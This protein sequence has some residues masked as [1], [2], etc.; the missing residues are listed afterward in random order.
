MKPVTE[1]RI[2]WGWPPAILNPNRKAHWGRRGHARA[3]YRQDCRLSALCAMKRWRPAPPWNRARID[4]V[5]YAPDARRRDEDNMV[6]SL[7]AAFDSLQDAG[8]IGDDYYLTR[9]S[10][11]RRIDRQRPRVEATVTKHP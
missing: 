3:Q 4:L 11:E 1:I 9:G 7:K 10:V 5:F 8:L 6:A 2:V